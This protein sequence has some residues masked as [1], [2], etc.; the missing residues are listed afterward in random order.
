MNKFV[1]ATLT[2]SGLMMPLTAASAHDEDYD[3]RYSGYGQH[4]RLHNEFEDA[5][6]R[7]HVEGFESRR[8]HRAYHRALRYLHREYHNDRPS[9]WGRYW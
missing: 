1:F 3:Y 8:K 9:H 7:A 2:A 5:H 6:E 4:A